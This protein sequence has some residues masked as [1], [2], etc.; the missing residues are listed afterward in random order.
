[1]EKTSAEQAKST[2]P[3]FGGGVRIWGGLLVI[4][5]LCPPQHLWWW[6]K[7][8]WKSIYA[9]RWKIRKNMLS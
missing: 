5:V 8:Y 2:S 6:I 3:P 1:M 7:A 9:N 4:G